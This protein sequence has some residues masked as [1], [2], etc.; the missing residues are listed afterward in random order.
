MIQLLRKLF[1]TSDRDVKSI[2]PIIETINAF[3]SG[4]AELTDA[5]LKA[6]TTE[7]RQRLAD[8]ATL[9]DILPEAFAVVREASLRLL[10]MRQ[11]D[12][13]LIGGVVLH[14]GRISEMKTGEGKT[15]VAVAPL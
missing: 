2:L 9:E 1:D 8:G 11:F 10:G 4:I 3:E 14:R 15:L 5:E 12:V 13:Q 7:F 6:K